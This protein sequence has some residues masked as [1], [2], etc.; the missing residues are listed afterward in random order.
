MNDEGSERKVTRWLRWYDLRGEAFAGE[1]QLMNITLE[2]LQTLFSVSAENPMYDCF[3]VQAPQVE[4]L[5][6]AVGVRIGLD[7]FDYFVEAESADG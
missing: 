3:R 6:L 1:A 5:E 2:E 4:R 7:E